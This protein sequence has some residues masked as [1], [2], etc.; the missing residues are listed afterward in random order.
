MLFR[1]SRETG[2]L[3]ILGMVGRKN[4]MRIYV[5]NLSYVDLQTLLEGQP[6][7]QDLN[8]FVDSINHSA[9]EAALILQEIYKDTANEIGPDVFADGGW[10][11]VSGVYAD[12]FSWFQGK[13]LREP[14]ERDYSVKAE[15]DNVGV[16]VFVL[17]GEPGSPF[18]GK[19]IQ[20][21]EESRA[22]QLRVL[23][24]KLR[25]AYRNN[26]RARTLVG[27]IM[28]LEVQRGRLL[29]AFNQFNRL[30]PA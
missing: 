11:Y 3:L 10:E 6:I 12:A 23:H 2:S 25:R 28:Q 1:I 4:Q 29:N 22:V 14:S 9:A 24:L 8:T 13:N 16:N 15:T 7:L 20:V 19:L 5:G 27:M 21:T 18:P 17:S 26:D 30:N